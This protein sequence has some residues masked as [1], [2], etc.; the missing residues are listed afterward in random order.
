MSPV[1]AAAARLPVATAALV[2]TT[3]SRPQQVLRTVQAVAV[4]GLV[5][6]AGCPGRWCATCV[7]GSSLLR[8]DAHC[9]EAPCSCLSQ[10]MQ[11]TFNLWCL[12]S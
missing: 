9:V 2:Q 6:L 11:L 3:A 1:T 4:Q 8:G 7:E 10:V 5:V 12:N